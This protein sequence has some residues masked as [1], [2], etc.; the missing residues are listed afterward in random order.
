M[1]LITENVV[2]TVTVLI[3]VL[4]MPGSTLVPD[5]DYQH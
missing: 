1:D 3:L 4:D 2:Q 5:N